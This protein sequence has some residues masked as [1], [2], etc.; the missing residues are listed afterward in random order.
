VAT[1]L[2]YARS[3]RRLWQPLRMPQSPARTVRSA[4]QAWS[5]DGTARPV[6]CLKKL[7]T[8]PSPCAHLRDIVISEMTLDGSGIKGPPSSPPEVGA[9]FSWMA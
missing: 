4:L 5:T 3:Q 2:V 7:D 8:S 9:G 1:T 6:S